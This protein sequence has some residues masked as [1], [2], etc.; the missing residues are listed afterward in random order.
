[1]QGLRIPVV[2]LVFVGA[3]GLA[4]L[5]QQVFYSRQVTAPLVTDLE[6][7]DGVA[8]VV[9]ES[10][11]GGTRVE[12]VLEPNVDLSGAYP[13]LMN[14]AMRRLGDN[15]TALHI[16]DGRDEHLEEAY[17]RL[18]FAIEESIV[19]GRFRALASTFEEIAGEMGLAHHRIVV[20]SDSIFVELRAGDAYLYEVIRRPARIPAGAWSLEPAVEGRGV[21]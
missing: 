9:L 17:Y 4:L 12:V 7:V 18:H 14:L 10:D 5:L 8:A 21:A 20:G 1:M 16:Q 3:L 2:V 19:T 13:K 11:G 15:L 6:T